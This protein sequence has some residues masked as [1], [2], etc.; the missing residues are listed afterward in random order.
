MNKTNILKHERHDIEGLRKIK[1]YETLFSRE[2][3]DIILIR[4][5]DI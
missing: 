1:K 4:K 2:E 3:E 5:K